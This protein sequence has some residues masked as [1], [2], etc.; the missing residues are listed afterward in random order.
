MRRKR[1]TRYQWLL[2]TGTVGPAADTDDTSSGRALAVNQ[3]ANATSS[4]AIVDLLNDT[5]SEDVEFGGATLLTMASSTQNEYFIKR[6]VGK[7]FIQ[8]SSLATGADAVLVGFG[9]FVARAGDFN[10]FAGAENLPIGP[11]TATANVDNYSPLGT[12]N[13]REPWIWRRTWVLG[14]PAQRPSAAGF[15]EYP[16]NTALYGSVLDGPHVDAKTARRVRDGERLWGV[17]AARAFPLNTASG[18]STAVNA[19]FDYRVLG[20]MRKGHNRSSF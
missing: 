2:P 19:Y 17:L 3:Q 6:I 15:A 1:K 16:Q 20:A 9:I 11:N 7:I 18:L 13:I 10:D 5:P 12:N 4:I 14:N 8:N